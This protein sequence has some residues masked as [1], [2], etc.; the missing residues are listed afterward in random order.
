MFTSLT[1]ACL[2][3]CAAEPEK[4][5]GAMPALPALAADAPPL[6][7]AQLE[8][9]REGLAYLKRTQDLVKADAWVPSDFRYFAEVLAET[10]RAAAE[11]E[12]KPANRVAWFE[13]RV[14]RLKEA[15]RL[16][17]RV[18][19]RGVV[20]PRDLNLIRFQR[21]QAEVDLLRLRE[22]AEKAGRK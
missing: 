19:R 6:R 21:I 8:L 22:E 16:I 20:A 4:P 14:G 17:D 15:E 13:A 3:L 9:V 11:L 10:C 12:E 7:K 18:A 1:S 5:A 2:L